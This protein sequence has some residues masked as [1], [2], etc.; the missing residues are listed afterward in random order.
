[1]SQP[2]H[3]IRTTVVIASSRRTHIAKRPARRVERREE[4][5]EDTR[6]ASR[7]QATGNDDTAGSLTE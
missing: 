1:M 7:R 4:R 2:P 3:D 6:Q 5:R